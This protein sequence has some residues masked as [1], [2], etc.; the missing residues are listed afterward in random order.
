MIEH[1]WFVVKMVT[2]PISP[3]LPAF[4]GGTVT[5]VP[6]GRA[7]SAGLEIAAVPLD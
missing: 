5:L 3:F 1:S 4:R 2:D 7:R 6:G